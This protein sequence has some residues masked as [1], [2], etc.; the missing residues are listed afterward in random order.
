MMKKQAVVTLG[1][2][3]LA[4]SA[5]AQNFS[6]TL[7]PSVQ[8]IDTSAGAV[9]ITMSVIGDA[10]VGTHMLDG[11]FS[12][13]SN[14]QLVQD[15]AWSPAS[16]SQFNTDGGYAGNGDYNQIAYGQLWP[17]GGIFPPPPN[18]ALGMTI[19]TFEI[20]LAGT[21]EVEFNLLEGTPFTLETIDE[22]N[23][24][25][26]I[27]TDGTLTLQG[28]S[29]TVVPAPAGFASLLICGLLSARRTREEA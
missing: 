3:G 6:L 26:Y 22:F 28:A 12:M 25:K 14:S 21:G 17:I 9:T 1:I 19:G 23:G 20:T 5:F 15:M 13:H 2:C 16:W 27:D 11:A 8:T 18:S 4:T 10:D 7:V 29:I 24:V